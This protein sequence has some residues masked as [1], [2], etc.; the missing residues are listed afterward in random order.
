MASS[1]LY[2]KESK[3]RLA[4]YSL[5]VFNE[6]PEMMQEL[7]LHHISPIALYTMIGQDD[8]LNP[9]GQNNGSLN[10]EERKM[11]QSMYHNGY[12]DVD[13]TFAYKLLKYFDIIPTPTQT[14]GRPPGS[15]DIL[16]SDDVERIRL[17]RNSLCHRASKEI[18]ETEFQE[19]FTDF[20]DIGSR[21]DTFLKKNP[22]NGFLAKI[23]SLKSD[24]I[25]VKNEEKYV[26]AL[27]EIC[28]LKRK[29]N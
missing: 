21:F 28:E 7:L 23:L 29:L 2:T 3:T 11:F 18:S 22:K 19:W 16:I 5:V 6:F 24:S 20:I 12:A 25:D 8:K 4:R 27:E 14:W 15:Y 17:Y 1:V 26:N 9:K 13:V 10:F